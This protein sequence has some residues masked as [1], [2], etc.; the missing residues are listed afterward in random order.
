MKKMI[1]TFLLILNS[2][3]FAGNLNATEQKEVQSII[4]L[5]QKNDVDNITKNI[6][7]PLIRENPVPD[8]QNTTEMKTRYTQVFDQTLRQTIAKSKLS[9]WSN[10]GWRGVMLDNGTV[11]LDGEKIRAINYSS[12]AEQQFKKQLI[13]QQKTMLYPTLKKFVQPELQ[14]KT[15]KFQVRIDELSNGQYR[16]AAWNIGKP[17][18]TKPNL[19]LNNGSMTFDGSGGNHYFNFKSGSYNYV[20]YRNI[21]GESATPDVTLSVKKN[22]KE[23]LNQSGQIFK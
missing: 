13:A 2:S 12:P 4:R 1:I 22:N 17:Q 14:F 6:R 10:V 11:W 8:I 7:Y 9:Q 5:F 21:I 15:A 23:I 18:S 3:A 19:V 16:Y 20:V